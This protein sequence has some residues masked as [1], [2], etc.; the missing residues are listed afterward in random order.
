MNSTNATRARIPL[1]SPRLPPYAS[2]EALEEWSFEL[3]ETMWA[4]FGMEQECLAGGFL[5]LVSHYRTAALT[6]GLEVKWT[7]APWLSLEFDRIIAHDQSLVLGSLLFVFSY[8]C[9]H[10]KSLALGCFAIM[11]ILLSM[12]MALFFYVVLFQ[13]PYFAQAR[14]RA[15]ARDSRVTLS[16]AWPPQP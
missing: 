2:D 15:R 4:A 11:Q 5:C 1:G 7:F 10:T 8:I 9:I 16:S 12:P 14:A 3:E 6:D 13:I